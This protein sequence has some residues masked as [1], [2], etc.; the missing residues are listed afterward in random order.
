M[1]ADQKNQSDSIF[2]EKPSQPKV[3]IVIRFS[4]V[5]SVSYETK[6]EKNQSNSMFKTSP[7]RVAPKRWEHLRILT[8][9]YAHSGL[10]KH[11]K[12]KPPAA[13]SHLREDL[14]ISR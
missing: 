11:V 13:I 9:F 1:N 5:E 10:R 6:L 2:K 12:L 4:S 14:R 8:R 3:V 7:G